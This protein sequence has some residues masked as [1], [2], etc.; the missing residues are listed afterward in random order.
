LCGGFLQRFSNLIGVY[1]ID[2]FSLVLLLSSDFIAIIVDVGENFMI[3]F[4]FFQIISK[5]FVSYST[6]FR[7]FSFLGFCPPTLFLRPRMRR[8]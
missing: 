2:H 5:V 4:I 1:F 3:F 7:I 8:I 6:T